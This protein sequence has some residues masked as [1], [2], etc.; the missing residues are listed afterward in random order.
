MPHTTYHIYPLFL[1]YIDTEEKEHVLYLVAEKK[2]KKRKR[3]P[4]SKQ[5]ALHSI[6][7]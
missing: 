5:S 3:Y 4:L 2:K 1:K 7:I 6:P